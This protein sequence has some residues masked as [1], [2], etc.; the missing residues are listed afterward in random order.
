MGELIKFPDITVEFRS[1]IHLFRPRT[2]AGR[3]WI[4]EQVEL[5]ANFEGESLL[6]E[7]PF[8]EGMMTA[9]LDDGLVLR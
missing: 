4:A 6:V 8:T 7:L 5:T 2:E 1:D 3:A 9:M